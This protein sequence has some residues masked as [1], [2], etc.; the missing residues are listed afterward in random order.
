MKAY[1]EL[2]SRL[3][4]K[5]AVYGIITFVLPVILLILSGNNYY[6]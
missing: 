4:N 5:M 1:S 3:W 6:K 2:F